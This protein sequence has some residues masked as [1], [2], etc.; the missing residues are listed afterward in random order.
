MR[1]ASLGVTS[2]R[3]SG[4]AARNKALNNASNGSCSTST[5]CQSLKQISVKDTAV[6]LMEVE[7]KVYQENSL[8][9]NG[10]VNILRNGSKCRI[11]NPAARKLFTED[12]NTEDPLPGDTN[13]GENS[14]HLPAYDLAGLSYNESQEPGELSQATALDFVD[15]FLKDNAMELDEEVDHGKSISGNS[16][17]VLSVKGPQ[18]LAKKANDKT[19]IGEMGIYDWDDSREDEGG[20]GIFCRRKEEFFGSRSHGQGP[21]KPK[22][23]ELEKQK[24]RK[25]KLN[26]NNKTMGLAYS[27]SRLVTHKLKVNDITF[28]EAEKVLKR[29]LVNEFNKESDINSLTRQVK[30]NSTNA[31][32]PQMSDVGFNTQM[33]AEAM[34]ALFCGEDIANP[35]VSDT[36]QGIQKQSISSPKDSIGKK[37]KNIR[38]SEQPKSLKRAR[39]SDVEVASRKSKK[40]RVIGTNLKK[41]SLV[42]SKELFDNLRKQLETRLVATKSRSAKSKT[43]QHFNSDRSENSSKMPCEIFEQRAVGPLTRGSNEFDRQYIQ[44]EIGILAPIA[45]RTRSKAVHL[46]KPINAAF[47]CREEMNHVIEGFAN[48]EKKSSTAGFQAS[49]VL[50]GRSSKHGATQSREADNVK[51]NQNQHSNHK[52]TAVTKKVNALSCSRGRFHR[53]LSNQV[54]ESGNLDGRC[55]PSIKPEEAGR[56]ITKH[57]RSCRNKRSS[58]CGCPVM[59]SALEGLPQQ[60]P[61]MVASED[62]ERACPNTGMEKSPRQ[63]KSSL[64]C[65]TP[66]NCSIPVKDASPVCMGDDSS[67]RSLSRSYLLKEISSLGATWPEPATPSKDLRRRREMTDVRVLY[68]QHLDDDII[69]QQK[70]VLFQQF[71]HLAIHEL[72]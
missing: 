8:G 66:L 36:Y 41:E 16:K 31:D 30:D 64:S 18:S 50:N 35:N 48:G 20:G 28:H 49:K 9:F 67:E 19:S 43:K 39:L 3:A 17:C 55:D 6:S 53:N 68:S 63:S 32:V 69:K 25:E 61:H 11:G 54:N 4:L 10:E 65:E 45:R 15:K 37:Q 5:S 62:N 52:M 13:E 72:I 23:N 56:S 33:A 70:K 42:P 7:G 34:E 71:P 22:T 14:N 24:A 38:C 1:L 47:G 2:L 46:K 27:D 40:T 60:R 29:N 57:K 59:S 58:R 51:E 26:G 44:G 12:P 21:R